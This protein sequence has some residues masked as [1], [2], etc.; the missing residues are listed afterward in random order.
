[1]LPRMTT[2]SSVVAFRYWLTASY[3]KTDVCVCACVRQCTR[4]CMCASAPLKSDGFRRGSLGALLYSIQTFM[5]YTYL[6]LQ[7][8]VNFDGRSPIREALHE[9]KH[10]IVKYLRLMDMNSRF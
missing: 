10:D 7:A 8:I 6:L 2:Y 5:Q 9:G 3:G 4:V 1:M